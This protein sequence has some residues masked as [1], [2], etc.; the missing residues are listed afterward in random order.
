M[1]WRHAYGGKIV[2]L[3]I[4]QQLCNSG[5]I[6]EA[7]YDTAS[8]WKTKGFFYR[9]HDCICKFCYHPPARSEQIEITCNRVVWYNFMPKMKIYR[10]IDSKKIRRWSLL[11]VALLQ[12]TRPEEHPAG[13][14]MY[15]QQYV[16]RLLA[17]HTHTCMHSRNNLRE[18]LLYFS[19][20]WHLLCK[21]ID[22]EK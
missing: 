16:W 2:L 7:F 11:P 4:Q 15:L 14:F 20:I 22:I 8:S 9:L 5:W 13:L 17:T 21:K 3:H 12:R 19:F 18:S 6:R 1:N 10:Y